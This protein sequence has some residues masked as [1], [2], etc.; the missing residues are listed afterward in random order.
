MAWSSD[1]L[2]SLLGSLWGPADSGCWLCNFLGLPHSE[3]QFP[4]LE[5]VNDEHLLHWI[6]AWEAGAHGLWAQMAWV[7]I[8]A[9]LV[10]SCV[11]GQQC[12][13]CASVFPLIEWD[14][15]VS[16]S[17]ARFTRVT[18]PVGDQWLSCGRL[19]GALSDAEL[20]PWSLPSRCPSH[21]LPC[22][23]QPKM[24][25]NIAR[26]TSPDPERQKSPVKNC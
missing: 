25:P 24:S 19:S 6:I 4:H 20:C 22:L 8:L 2:M 11:T 5:S 12:H 13:L 15:M 21:P 10:T 16:V 17:R 14:D 3:P 23:S 9:L 1:R 7:Q 26:C 18:I